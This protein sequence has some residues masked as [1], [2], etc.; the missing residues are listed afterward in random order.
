MTMIARNFVLGMS[1][2]WCATLAPA[3]EFAGEVRDALGAA[4]TQPW[5]ERY[6]ALFDACTKQHG[7]VG[8]LLGELRDRAKSD[9]AAT[10]AHAGWILGFVNWR[11]GRLSAAKR[12]VDGAIE[13]RAD[14]MTRVRRARLLEA[15]GNTRDAEA[16]YRQVL[17]LECDE[18][19][20]SFVRLRLAL[21]A[22]RAQGDAESAPLVEFAQAEG[23][24][25]SVR[26]RA[27]NVLALLGRPKDAC[28]LFEVG[29]EGTRRFRDEVR[30][31]TWAIQAGELEQAEQHAWRAVQAAQLR[32]D[33]SYALSVL[34]EAHRRHDSL[35]E[36][37]KRFSAAETLDEE[38]RAVWIDLL[39]ETGRVD[40]AV[41]LFRSARS[42]FTV[43]MQRELIEMYREAGRDDE[44]ISTYRELIAA[45]PS[46]LTWR[47]GLSRFFL[48]HG[49][50]D[51]A[52][53]VW[54]PCLRDESLHGQLL[55]V[56]ATA[57]ELGL[58]DV[59]TEAAEICIRNDRSRHPALLLL[60]SSNRARGRLDEA[61]AALERMHE[62]APA[63]SPDRAALSEAF[64]Q[65]GKLDRAIEIIDGLRT[66]RGEARLA[67]DLEIRLAWLYSQVGDDE[68]AMERWFQLWRR[69]KSVA[70]RRYVEDR[71]M[72]VAA[73]L[74]KIAKIVV[75]LESRLARGEADKQDS[76]LLVRLYTK[77]NDP[78]SAAE[79]IDEFFRQSGGKDIEAMQEKA[80]VYLACTDYASY[81]DTVRQLM[82]LDPEGEVDYLRSLV[83]SQLERGRPDE[84]RDVLQR[85]RQAEE[86]FDSA[87]FEA[88]VL[89]LAGLRDEAIGCYQRG[90]ATHP[91]RIE[92]YLLLAN[93]LKEAGNTKRAVGMFQHIA[94]TAEKDDLFTIAIDGLLN[95][96]A[97]PPV[98]EWARRVTLERIAGRHDKMYLYQLLS[99]LSDELKNRDGMFDALEGSLA[100]AGGR[101]PSILRELM[102][103][104]KGD[105]RTQGDSQKQ[106]AYGRRLVSLSEV[107]PPQVYLDLGQAF[108]DADEISNAVK[109]F[110]LA[111]DVA[112]YAAFRRQ[113]AGL[114]ETAGYLRQSLRTYKQVL[115]GN[116]GDISLLVKVAGLEE[117][118]GRD[119][120]AFDLYRRAVDLMVDRLPIASDK[121]KKPDE[122]ND[123]MFFFAR[124][125]D[126]TGRYLDQAV[127]G[128]LV[129]A[130]GDAEVVEE[131]GRQI[132]RLKETIDRFRA[133]VAGGE[134]RKLEQSPKLE[135]LSGICRRMAFAI[136]RPDLVA[137]ADRQ[138]VDVFENDDEILATLCKERMRW[139]MTG[140]ARELVEKCGQPERIKKPLR[141]LFGAGGAPPA[142][143]IPVGQVASLLLPAVVANDAERIGTLIL[144]ADLTSVSEKDLT[145]LPALL[146]AARSAGNDTAALAVSQAWIRAMFAAKKRSYEITNVHSQCAAG[147]GPEA[148]RRFDEFFLARITKD[149]K[150]AREFMHMLPQ[151]QKRYEEP[152]LTA[153]Q[154]TELIEKSELEYPYGFGKLLEMVAAEERASVLR[155]RW[156]QIAKTKRLS[157]IL[158]IASEIRDPLGD[159]L[160]EFLIDAIPAAIADNT[161]SFRYLSHS[162]SELRDN[163]EN[164]AVAV[165]IAEA[166]LKVRPDEWQPKFLCAVALA[167]K[168][169]EAAALQ[170]AVEAVRPRWNVEEDYEWR[171]TVSDIA[172]QFFPTHVDAFLATYDQIEN[173]TPKMALRRLMLV[174][175]IEDESRQLEE[176][177]ATAEKFPKDRELGQ[178]VVRALD[179]AGQRV[180]ALAELQRLAKALPKDKKLQQQLARKL[181]SLDRNVE[182][183]AVLDAIDKDK[184]KAVVDNAAVTAA[185]ATKTPPAK[186]ARVR[187]LLAE[188]D[189]D[190][191]R[192][193]FRRLWRFGGSGFRFPPGVMITMIGSSVIRSSFG[194]RGWQ[195]WPTEKKDDAEREAAE[196]KR[197]RG[198]LQAFS[199]EEPKPVEGRK[200]YEVLGETE[201]GRAE[202]QRQLRSLTSFE[203][204][205]NRNLI[206]G[207]LH[208][209]THG[210]DE[211]AVFEAVLKRVADGRANRAHYVQ[212]L[213]LMGREFAKANLERSRPVLEELVRTV[214]PVDAA[215]VLRLAKVYGGQGEVEAAALLYRWC[216][217]AGLR[218]RGIG[219]LKEVV[220]AAKEHLEKSTLIAL[221]ED[222]LAW[223]EPED[224]FWFD[225]Y[226]IAVLEIWQDIVGPDEA[227]ERCRELCASIVDVKNRLRRDSARVAA[228]LLARAGELDAA[229][230][231]LEVGLCK[232][233]TEGVE[234]EYTFFLREYERFGRASD[235]DLRR[236]FPADSGTWKDARGWYERVATELKSWVE[237]RR[238]NRDLAARMLSLV[239]VRMHALGAEDAA[240][241]LLDE[242]VAWP[243]VSS[244]N[245][246]WIVDAIRMNGEDDRAFALEREMLDARS[247]VSARVP[248]VVRRIAEVDGRDSALQVASAIADYSWSDDLLD[249]LAELAEANGDADGAAEWRS[250][251]SRN[252][253]A[254]TKLEERDKA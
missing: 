207:L 165:R 120:V 60:A 10:A 247:L 92:I 250:K 134:T 102:E 86:G 172:R 199:D 125:V 210:A 177:R 28:G 5:S 163:S 26:N 32:R 82:E 9:D 182:A 42:E 253:A 185:R 222:A 227:L 180:E 169:D 175:E 149:M 127:T 240:G 174:D 94:E 141:Y 249:L 215:Q 103:L 202:M 41:A 173:P 124:N 17:E 238:M 211:L 171:T 176:I 81:E 219:N 88:G 170:M 181:R 150:K 108:L 224:S 66:A 200:S 168:G 186:I 216:A 104:A 130:P 164:L 189:V 74:G 79:V 214:D 110:D 153:E 95:M 45:D 105:R 159:D 43:D 167:Q 71:L 233:P 236:L 139:G 21:L 61:E 37:M 254:R 75:E 25:A 223:A 38:T 54:Q 78:V 3:Q 101:R 209:A 190:A 7:G 31:A 162:F 138:I 65:L 251:A 18:A 48:E 156:G 93:L 226:E 46:S 191:A 64:E 73:R 217:I 76:G 80:R 96:E 133:A 34:V 252:E 244:R 2:A 237:T 23:R 122:N 203:I 116:P 56:A 118:V 39:R 91:N 30:V 77:V 15:T 52:R 143:A 90:I 1:L 62:M 121:N 84:A 231:C 218:G 12:A 208:G 29:G 119:G 232:L 70:R 99:D 57:M 35:E 147:L 187:D 68:T 154:V 193:E 22:L 245:R 98:L 144:K 201:F 55:G 137:D 44:L 239:S 50:V 58:D 179:R 69:V 49:D 213:E 72:T 112:D 204:D 16:E 132:G 198:G 59:A 27:A 87:E 113:V 148:R 225:E 24:D 131:A 67:E 83:M 100:I 107:V 197:R 152:L 33:R 229:V 13:H 115:L 123:R 135:K 151:M 142:R 196:A 206:D 248:G 140:S 145:H 228:S 128:M 106:L 20:E 40:E 234:V 230:R 183:L 6:D 4:L 136:C 8:P 109:T 126:D 194:S 97:P 241:A 114:Y 220:D 246:L 205:S 89:A 235:A 178:R 36:L 160:S 188:S 63:D 111:R 212:L 19:T 195:T 221:V 146:T 157:F 161:E 85:L 192:L 11:D 117:Q 14:A 184:P 47:E 158:T 155:A 53:E 243:D 129:T 242:V 51:S 166:V